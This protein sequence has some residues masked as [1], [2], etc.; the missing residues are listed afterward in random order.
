MDI[1]LKSRYT[2]SEPSGTNFFMGCDV[3]CGGTDAISLVGH[4]I[5]TNTSNGFVYMPY[6]PLTTSSTSNVDYLKYIEKLRTQRKIK[7]R[8]AK[9]KKILGDD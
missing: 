4:K 1:I 2:L 9:I 8:Q 3:A 7:D 5:T 6:I